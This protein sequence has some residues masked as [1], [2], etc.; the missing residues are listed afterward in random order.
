VKL[1]TQENW[2]GKNKQFDKKIDIDV[3]IK[4]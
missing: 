4:V 2:H 3:N 1:I